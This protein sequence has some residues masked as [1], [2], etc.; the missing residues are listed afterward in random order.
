[1]AFHT[2]PAVLGVSVEYNLVMNSLTIPRKAKQAVG[3]IAKLSNDETKEV[4]SVFFVFSLGA[5]VCACVW[6]LQ[7]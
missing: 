5:C 3:A 4:R 7:G 6:E 2:L 1:M